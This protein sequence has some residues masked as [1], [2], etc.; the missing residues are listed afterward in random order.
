MVLSLRSFSLN[1]GM[2][3]D[4][5]G[6][7]TLIQQFKFDIIFLQEIRATKIDIEGKIGD[8]GYSC[9]VNIDTEDLS[10]PGVA[11]VWKSSLPLTNVENLLQCRMQVAFINGYAFLNIYAPSGA[12]KRLERSMFFAEEVFRIFHLFKGFSW[13]MGGDYNSILSPLDVEN[14]TGYDQK[15]CPQLL[16]LVSGLGLTDVFRCFYPRKREFT[17]FRPNTAP[18]RLDRFYVSLNLNNQVTS[19]RHVASL[20]DHHGIYF[21]ASLDII[22]V[23][24]DA[25]SCKSSYWKLNNMILKDEELK[26]SFGELWAWLQDLKPEFPDIADWW[27]EAV[28]PSIKQLCINYSRER[29]R[30]RAASKYFSFAYL[31][32]ALADKNWSEV[33][34]T[35]QKLKQL[36]DE[37][38]YGSIVRSRF[39][40]N[41]SSE[42]ASIFHSNIEMRNGKKNSLSKLKINGKIEENVDVIEEEVIGFFNALF[43]GHHDSSLV[44]TGVPFN[45]DYVGLQQFLSG[46]GSLPDDVKNT[47]EEQLTLEEL[48]YVVFHSKNNKSPGLD[49]ISYEFF[50]FSWD[51]IQ[52]DLLKVFQCQLDRKRIVASNREG[53]TRLCPKTSSVPAV[54]ELRPITLLN[55]DYKLLSKVLVKR[56]RPNLPYVITSGQLCT[57]GK[58]NI[59][60]GISNILSTIHNVKLRKSQACIISLDFFKAYDRVFLDFLLKVMAQMNFGSC[61]ISWIEMLH[62]GAK[63]RFILNFLTSA[64]EVKFSIRQGDPIAMILYIIYIEPLLNVLEK[65]LV[66]FKVFNVVQRQFFVDEKIEA[67]CDDVNVVT[68]DLMDFDRLSDTVIKFESYS[69]AILSRNNKCKV[70]GLGKWS[71]KSDWPVPWLDSAS[72]I[73]IFGIFISNNYSEIVRVNWEYRLEKFKSAIMAW[74]SRSLA[75]IQQKVEVV[76]VFGLSRIY[77]VAS[78]LPLGVGFVKKIESIIGKFIWS[79]SGLLR[80]ALD[81]LKNDKGS[82]GLN[83]PC[84]LSMNKALM[85]SQ[86]IR[87]LNSGDTKSIGHMEY[88]MGSFLVNILPWMNVASNSYDT[89]QYYSQLGD[90]LATLMINETLTVSS[91]KTLTN[92]AIY[93]SLVNSPIP[94]IVVDNPGLNYSRIWKRLHKYVPN[95]NQD[96]MLKL[97]H[98]KLP[99][100]E[101]L[102]RI[103]IIDTSVCMYCAGQVADIVHYFCCCLKTR[104]TWSWLRLKILNMSDAILLS[105]NWELLNLNFPN[106]SNAAEIVWLVG[107]YVGFTWKY[108]QKEETELK[109]EEFFGFLSF[110]YRE[111][112]FESRDLAW[113]N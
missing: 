5:A 26:L 53:V 110:K 10:R 82:G 31:K 66:G 72:V 40:G 87:L 108:C 106:V 112:G 109:L 64:I 93:K 63:T 71:T 44:D 56:L 34:R 60:Y 81:E 69:G 47:M 23:P 52:Q 95:E 113:L 55:S 50:K 46:L 98:N 27:D 76:K 11:F 21:D 13:V 8:L 37:D 2:R 20:S 22:K 100:K 17:F 57:V 6:L 54:N 51:L 79:G 30:R 39:G 1:V 70:M 25:S 78:I 96:I 38:M 33:A 41:A 91:V 29:N 28:K 85:S 15:K 107:H 48:E 24:V 35:R 92:R 84:I 42:V 18:S 73:K 19:V 9:E 99:V 67:Y 94:K 102:H 75:S 68:D 4:L 36:I 104:R 65:K 12:G 111:S 49:G 89:P 86:C 16:D 90:C 80:I 14:G 88:W 77:Y 103:G 74:S 59:L 62:H 83:L 7:R 61:F 58:K 101:R 43:N 32:V 105:S 3:S 45:P 97:L